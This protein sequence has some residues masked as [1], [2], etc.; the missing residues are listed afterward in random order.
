MSYVYNYYCTVQIT[1]SSADVY[2]SLVGYKIVAIICF[3]WPESAGYETTPY[4]SHVKIQLVY[5]K[6][7]CLSAISPAHCRIVKVSRAATIAVVSKISRHQLMQ[8]L[9][10]LRKLF[11]KF[12]PLFYSFIPNGFTYYSQNSHLLFSMW[13]LEYGEYY[14]I[15]AALKASAISTSWPFLVL[16]FIAW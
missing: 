8:S 13:Q 9:E 14:R 11:P 7:Q 3:R 16:V 6:H 5:Q 2:C 12:Y 15:G 1:N 4:T 10:G